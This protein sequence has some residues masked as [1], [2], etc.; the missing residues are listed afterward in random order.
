M[1][2]VI[3]AAGPGKRI[4]DIAPNL[5]KTLVPV[6]GKPM[7]ARILESFKGRNLSEIIVTT[8]YRA[9]QIEEFLRKF[10]RDDLPPTRTVLND[11]YDDTNYIFSLWLARDFL[12]DEDILLIHGDMAYDCR[13][14]DSLI[15]RDGST[16]T[17]SRSTV[18]S[19]K[20]F[21]ARIRD[22]KVLE[23]AVRIT[24]DDV[25]PCM[26]L[27]KWKADDFQVWMKSIDSFISKGNVKCYAE[28][29]FNVLD[30][31][32]E[33]NPVWYKDELCMEIDNAE[34]LSLAESLLK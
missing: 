8:G 27:Y 30:G 21:N 23:V 11:R 18:P 13:L 34:D 5:P 17:V 12:H 26:P 3:L 24:G 14:L 31:K 7:L 9:E 4:R 33:L 1:K 10:P 20:D 6:A 28:D 2:A 15:V 29:A 32:I 22:G 19:P 16:V 25:H